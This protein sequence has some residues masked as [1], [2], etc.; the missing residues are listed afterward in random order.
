MKWYVDLKISAKLIT[1]FLVVA[2]LAAV[3][4]VIG[5]V[6]IL[7]IADDDKTLYKNDTVGLSSTGTAAVYFQQIRYDLVKMLTVDINDKKSMQTVADDIN[8]QLAT[9]N[10]QA[11]EIQPVLSVGKN[12]EQYNKIVTELTQYQE[13]MVKIVDSFVN[14]DG[15]YAKANVTPVAQLGT[16]IRDDF[17]NLFLQLTQEAKVTSDDNAKAASTATI[18]MIIAAVVAVAVALIL[19]AYISRLLGRPLRKMAAV[20]SM[21]AGGDIEVYHV[22]DDKDM[23][24]KF[25][26]DEIGA[27]ADGFNK[28][29]AKTKQQVEEIQKLSEGDLTIHFEVSSEKD[30][31]GKGLVML[32]DNLN[33]LIG[34]IITA[35]EQVTSG[36]SMVSHSSISL[37]SGATEQASSVQQLTASLEVIA[38][39]TNVNAQSAEKANDLALQAR[40]NAANGNDHMKEML[41]AMDDITVSSGSINKIIKVIDDIAFRQIFWH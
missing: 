6:N 17:I 33:G 10:Q 24:L 3:V 35:S 34:S 19:G 30:L 41:R 26:K 39:Q 23:K 2:I 4:G 22:L 32:T 5:I 1:G 36:A 7:T 40:E 20:A 16:T 31:L 27:L 37:S 14:G 21:L 9:I 12:A 13:G 38:S 18:V 8:K 15:T 28:L 29:I 11:K 25:Q